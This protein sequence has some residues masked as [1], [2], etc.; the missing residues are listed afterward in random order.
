MAKSTKSTKRKIKLDLWVLEENLVILEL[1]I[2]TLNSYIKNKIDIPHEI[3]NLYSD[4]FKNENVFDYDQ[5]IENLFSNEVHKY[6]KKKSEELKIQSDIHTTTE[7]IMKDITEFAKNRKRENPLKLQ[8]FRVFIF[9]IVKKLKLHEKI[10]R[11]IE[12]GQERR[13]IFLNVFETIRN[14]FTVKEYRQT[15][16]GDFL[17]FDQLEEQLIKDSVIKII[18]SLI[19]KKH[20]F[21]FKTDKHANQAE[22]YI[23]SSK[24]Y[25]LSTEQ[26]SEKGKKR[27]QKKIDIT[28]K[29]IANILNRPMKETALIENLCKVMDCGQRKTK[30]ILSGLI[31]IKIPGKKKAP[32]FLC[33]RNEKGEVVYF[34]S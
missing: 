9:E 23:N 29:E 30:E 7:A 20:Y 15:K 14:E 18:T 26:K 13:K 10:P 16:Q 2:S 11:V 25:F 27:N 31:G 12:S 8:N 17:V 28:V 1:V 4:L 6:E 32:V 3:V 22:D 24:H 5:L 33:K 21:N 34:L 19:I